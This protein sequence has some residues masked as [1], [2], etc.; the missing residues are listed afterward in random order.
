MKR[1]L[2]YVVLSCGLGV[3][4]VALAQLSETTGGVAKTELISV[5]NAGQQPNWYVYNPVI[6]ADGRFVVFSSNATNLVPGGDANSEKM[7]VFVRDRIAGTTEL[8]SVNSDGVQGDNVSTQASISGDGRY[9]AFISWAT[10]LMSVGEINNA[11][12]VFVRDRLT[13]KTEL[14]S[15]NSVGEPADGYSQSPVMSADGRFV[16]FYS[17]AGNLVPGDDANGRWPDVFVH[18]RLSGETEL[19]SVSSTGARGNDFSYAPAI[20]ADGRFVAFS[21]RS[22]NFIPGGDANGTMGDVFVRD[23]MTGTTE[24]VSVDSSGTQ[25]N[26]GSGSIALSADGRYVTFSSSSTTFIPGGDANGSNVDA[27]IHDRVTG[28][29]ELVGVDS[30]GVQAQSGFS[31]PSDVS[32]DGRFVTVYA[33]PGGDA[34]GNAGDVFIRDRVTGMTELVSLNSSDEPSNG[35]SGGGSMSDSGRFV[36][37]ISY[38]TNMIPG[39]D[40]NGA[41]PDIFVRDRGNQQPTANAGPDRQVTCASID[42]TAVTLDG[43]ASFDTDGDLLSYL[44]SGP[45]VGATGS[46]SGISPTVNLPLGTSAIDLVVNDGQLDSNPDR[47]VITVVPRVEGFQAPLPTLTQEPATPPWP[48]VAFKAG[49]TLP[50]KVKLSCGGTALTDA[51]IAAPELVGLTV[52]GQT[53]IDVTAIDLDSGTANDEGTLFRFSS[54][55]YWV[56]NLSTQTLS[57]N[58]IYR[59]TIRMP[60]GL[61]YS[62]YLLLK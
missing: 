24:V 13:G 41:M 33:V 40:T 54:D 23:R 44:W 56:Y 42:S 36:A 59:I 7:D 20:S 21:S 39:G 19:V 25:G 22:T 53:P 52:I 1:M 30:F 61:K 3:A 9:V 48:D 35:H 58:T 62:A 5:N 43:S 49:R 38:G 34:N 8:V 15:V 17:V 27:F 28:V 11:G 10:N 2:K 16:A 4:T 31:I 32:A 29:T 47:V 45:F 12:N 51:D 60:D 14:V 57:G 26:L 6:S 50:L 55:G 18:D 46:V 37:F